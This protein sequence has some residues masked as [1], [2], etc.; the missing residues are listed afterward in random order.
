ME[1]TEITVSI[2][3]LTLQQT[4][5]DH[6]Q[7]QLTDAHSADRPSTLGQGAADGRRCYITQST[8]T[9]QT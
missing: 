2:V 9:V 5:A 1:F 7:P 4:D 8:V 3:T 6:S